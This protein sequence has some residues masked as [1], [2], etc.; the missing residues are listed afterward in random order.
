MSRVI[1]KSRLANCA[2][3]CRPFRISFQRED[4][5]VVK[6]EFKRIKDEIAQMERYAPK[7]EGRDGNIG[8]D[9]LISPVFQNY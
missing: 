2:S 3:S 7:I 8:F 6:R 1:W 4:K 5:S 9:C